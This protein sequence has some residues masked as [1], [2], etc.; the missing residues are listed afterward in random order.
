MLGAFI[1]RQSED[2]VIEQRL[3]EGGT[4]VRIAGDERTPDPFT[5]FRQ[6]VGRVAAAGSE[7]RKDGPLR[8]SEYGLPSAARQGMW[9]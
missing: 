6:D 8:V 5:R 7:H 3:V 9:C 4:G 2:F 1:G